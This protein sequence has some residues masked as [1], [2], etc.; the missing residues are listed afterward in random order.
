MAAL[1]R[2]AGP[3]PHPRRPR[4][5]LPRRSSTRSPGHRDGTSGTDRRRGEPKERG[6]E[7][8]AKDGDLREW[9]SGTGCE[10]HIGPRAAQGKGRAGPTG[11]G[12]A[13]RRQG[14]PGPRPT[15]RRRWG[16]ARAVPRAANEPRPGTCG[17]RPPGT[18]GSSA[19]VRP[20]RGGRGEWAEPGRGGCE[21][22]GEKGGVRGARGGGGRGGAGPHGPPG[23]PALTGAASPRPLRTRRPLRLRLTHFRPARALCPPAGAAGSRSPARTA[24]PQPGG[25]AALQLPAGVA[26]A[27][28]PLPPPPV[29]RQCAQPFRRGAAPRAG[30]GGDGARRWGAASSAVRAARARHGPH[31]RD[32]AGPLPSS[33]IVTLPVCPT[34]GS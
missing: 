29:A 24:R 9:D 26:R 21:G 30:N 7:A 6:R 31:R 8:R 20:S 33:P 12:A 11:P 13:R 10:K 23:A 4:Q 18:G 15:T 19:A 28:P 32:L 27:I 17:A 2:G 3:R 14:L 22:R 25:S 1:P 5:R 16:R 34:C